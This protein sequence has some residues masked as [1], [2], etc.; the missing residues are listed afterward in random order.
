MRLRLSA[1]T[2]ITL[3]AL[4]LT[5]GC[6]EPQHGNYLEHAKPEVPAPATKPAPD[7][8]SHPE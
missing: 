4:G 7:P 1:P 3:A 5:L 2:I 6:L 8:D